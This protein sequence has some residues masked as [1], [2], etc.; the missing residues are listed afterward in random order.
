VFALI[1]FFRRKLVNS[2]AWQFFTASLHPFS[3]ASIVLSVT[4]P[5][6]FAPC[7][8]VASRSRR[9]VK[10]S[11]GRDRDAFFRDPE[12]RIA[13]VRKSPVA[14]FGSRTPPPY[15]GKSVPD[16]S[17][18]VMLPFFSSRIPLPGRRRSPSRKNAVGILAFFA[19]VDGAGPLSCPFDVLLFFSS[20]RLLSERNSMRW[21]NF[22]RTAML[23]FFPSPRAFSVNNRGLSLTFPTEL[24]Y[25][26]P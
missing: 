11:L 17:L 23:S 22:P 8:P 21:L 24:C 20:Q 19:F 3:P 13:N 2:L 18:Y 7:Q 10:V 5:F 14:L 26:T 6:L 16:A 9:A 25:S 1:F 15:T 12:G 4:L